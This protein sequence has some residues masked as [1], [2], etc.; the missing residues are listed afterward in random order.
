MPIVSQLVRSTESEPPAGKSTE[1]KAALPSSAAQNAFDARLATPIFSGAY[2]IF[3]G[4]SDLIFIQIE[5]GAKL[6]LAVMAPLIGPVVNLISLVLW[7]FTKKKAKDW[8]KKLDQQNPEDL[9]CESEN[10]F[11]LHLPE[12]REAAIELPAFLAVSG[13]AGRLILVARH[14]EKMKFEFENATE[15]NKAIHLLVP[16]L[17]PTLKVNVEWNGAKRR[18]EKKKKGGSGTV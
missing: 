10:N 6:V 14:G 4:Q 7:F 1:K 18:F 17:N 2:R 11:R 8:L 5:G 9:L 15:T 16:L 12:I 3:V 13:K